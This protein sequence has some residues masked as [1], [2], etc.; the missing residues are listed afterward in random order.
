MNNE[1][2]NNVVEDVPE[3]RSVAI[4][5]SARPALILPTPIA[6]KAPSRMS[7]P[8]TKTVVGHSQSS[9]WTVGHSLKPIPLFYLVERTSTR[10]ANASPDEI[11]ARISDFLR[12]QSVAA[13][14]HDEEVRLEPPPKS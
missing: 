8:E 5:S 13:K 4:R 9:N 10:I 6:A 1:D 12:A 2:N 3:M 7:A 14:F 11:A